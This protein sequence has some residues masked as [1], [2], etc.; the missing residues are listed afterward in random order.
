MVFQM[1]NRS[2]LL[3]TVIY[4]LRNHKEP[5]TDEEL[6]NTVR[7][8]AELTGFECNEELI[9]YVINETKASTNTKMDIG[10]SLSNQDSTHDPLWVDKRDIQWNYNDAYIDFLMADGWPPLVVNSLSN[11]TRKI[12]EHL[13]DPTDEGSWSRKGL[14]IGNVQ[15]G[16][17]ANYTGLIARAADAGYKIIIVIAGIHNN[18]RNQTQSRIDE[19][20]IGRSSKYNQRQDVGVSIGREYQYPASVTNVESDF[21]INTARSLN[22]DL[23]SFNRPIVF[24]IKKN[25]HTLRHLHDWLK[26][27]NSKQNGK[28]TDLPLLLIDDEADNASINTNKEEEDPTQTNAGIRRILSLFSKS[29][30]IGYTATPF[31]NIF[32]DSEAEHNDLNKDLFPKDFIYC[33]DA[34]TNY[35]G[36]D[37]IFN[38]DL[39]EQDHVVIIDDAENYISLSHKKDEEI[40]DLPPSLYEA[41]Y[42]FILV[43][44][45][46]NLRGQ[47][48]QHCSMM[49]NVSRFVAY[50]RK[51]EALL[52]LEVN[53]LKA[54]VLSN[55][56]LPDEITLKDKRINNL[57]RILESNF[58]SCEF[59]WNTIKKE[60]PNAFKT[61]KTHLINSESGDTLDFSLYEKNNIGLTALAVG[62]LSL[63][64]GLTIE[65]LSISYLYRNTQMYDTLMQMGRW[66]GYRPNYEDLCRIYLT[67][68]SYDWYA[69]ISEASNDLIHQIHTMSQQ[70]KTPEDFGLIVRSHPD[71]LR[72]TALNKMRHAESVTFQQ[73]YSGRISE[74]HRVPLDPKINEKNF[75]LIKE[76]WKNN[77]YSEP[78]STEDSGKGIIFK[79]VPLTTI[80]KFLEDF[81]YHPSIEQSFNFTIKYLRA[82]IR[83][84]IF[85]EKGDVLLVSPQSKNQT[86]QPFTMNSQNRRIEI[87]QWEAM[88]CWSLT[89]CRVAGA[90]DEK[91]GLTKDE[92]AKAEDLWIKSNNTSQKVTKA[93]SDIHYRNARNRVLLMLHSLLPTIDKK[94]ANGEAT[95]PVASL[96]ISFPQ[97]TQNKDLVTIKAV[98]NKVWLQNELSIPEEYNLDEIYEYE[99]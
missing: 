50:Q 79:N 98:A 49:V 75:E 4:A 41:L 51:V 40:T 81:E 69:H 66:F 67:R 25:V 36:A 6:S 94:P 24:V 97:Q 84:N 3:K 35:F 92:L 64:R 96:G 44:A 10:V 56:S 21:N 32:I 19:S 72:I 65:G 13:Q 60:L 26:E 47:R 55:T 63:S 16:K 76:Y 58:P 48:D 54:S 61:L 22:I 14:V 77:F 53:R 37:K 52:S 80:L 31:A 28:I 46:R 78:I 42:S 5:P 85:P 7:F 33:L 74:V 8:L 57:K 99:E 88:A 39:D 90:G 83:E 95:M 27:L 91:F 70:N 89:Q 93:P 1:T 23:N 30:Y 18:L 9:D 71:S 11:T 82:A 87:S 29:A 62:G 38:N 86:N 17:T 12:L 2:E 15:S 73:S 34:P 20:F 45:I 43:R 59:D 68:E